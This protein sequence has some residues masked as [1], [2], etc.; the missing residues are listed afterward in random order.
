MNRWPGGWGRVGPL[1]GRRLCGLV[2]A[3]CL[4]FSNV[5][6]A[7]QP[8]FDAH[9]HY[10][11]EHAEAYP[12]DKVV[13]I[14]KSSQVSAAVVTGRPPEQVLELHARAPSL[15]LPVLGVYRTPGDKQTWMDDSGLPGQVERHLAMGEWKG[16]GEM[17]L[18]A[19]D[20]HS[21]VFQRIVALAA[22][23]AIPLLMHCDP[24]VID[25]IF[26]HRPEASVV[27]AHAGAYPY[28]TLLRDYLER[29]P[30]LYVD[31]SVRDDRVA[32]LGKLSA[33]WE[34]LLMEHSDR[35][36]VGMDTFRTERWGIYAALIKRTRHWLQQL[37]TE[38]AADIGR[39]N[40]ERLF[41][42]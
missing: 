11:V 4:V 26:V 8:L 34:W 25:S 41:V 29:Y 15:I 37:P 35:F 14:L 33:D 42:Q 17:H 1:D 6:G 19:E 18:F 7:G 38:V 21:P 13:E 28:P 5:R 2:L 3:L 31:L 10:N 9:L 30:N 22:K 23:H 32:P 12:P 39:R 24:A 27:W 16:I 36:L 20:R 40:G